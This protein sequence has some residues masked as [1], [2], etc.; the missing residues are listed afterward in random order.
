M[1]I[2][3]LE[4]VFYYDQM[5]L[6]DMPGLTPQQV[7]EEYAEI[8]PELAQGVVEGPDLTEEGA[9]YTF[10]KAAGVKGG[11][12]VTVAQLAEG[13][14]PFPFIRIAEEIDFEADVDYQGGI[15]KGCKAAGASAFRYPRNDLITHRKERGVPGSN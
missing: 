6:E 4:R 9:I 11:N 14:I 2:K 8:Y 5:R 13:K 7:M 1:A 3:E 15:E 12:K 10:R